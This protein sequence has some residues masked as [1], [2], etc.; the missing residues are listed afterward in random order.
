VT[1]T[2]TGMNSR[3]DLTNEYRCASDIQ[4]YATTCDVRV[5]LEELGIKG[6]PVAEIG[7]D[8]HINVDD[9]GGDRE[10]KYSWCSGE[11]LTAWEDMSVVDC[12][13]RII[14]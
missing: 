11:T 12:S 3:L 14:Q 10:A 7:F 6:M 2:V 5:S 9:D 4:G 13:L 8:V 1:N